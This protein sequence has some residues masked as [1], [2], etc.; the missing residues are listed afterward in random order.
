MYGL[1][2]IFVLS[3]NNQYSICS[4]PGQNPLIPRVALLAQ[5][6][7]N[8]NNSNQIESN[9]SGGTPGRPAYMRRPPGPGRQPMTQTGT[10]Q[11]GGQSTVTREKY[12]TG[13]VVR[14]EPGMGNN[15]GA[16]PRRGEPGSTG[17]NARRELGPIKDGKSPFRCIH[18]IHL[19][20]IFSF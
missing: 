16:I 9:Q 3:C 2:G 4:V 10:R 8:A 17:T 15:G 11:G 20:K 12:G 18:V 13:A 7:Q 14:R 1:K 19:S 5:Q 6:K